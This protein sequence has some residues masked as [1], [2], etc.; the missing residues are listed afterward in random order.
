MPNSLLWAMLVVLW[1]FVV[2]PMFAGRK[3]KVKKTTEATLA[4]RVV[5]SGGREPARARV[6]A[7]GSHPHDAE[8][9][10]PAPTEPNTDVFELEGAVIVSVDPASA[11]AVAASVQRVEVSAGRSALDY[12]DTLDVND[13]AVKAVARDEI[14][15]AADI[16]DDAVRVDETP[17]SVFAATL[18]AAEVVVAKTADADADAPAEGEAE[19][20]ESDGVDYDEEDLEIARREVAQLSEAAEARPRVGRGGFDPDADAERSERRIKFRQRVALGLV[21]LTV[22]AAVVGFALHPFGWVVATITGVALV[23]YLVQ[24]RRQ[25]RAELEL[26]RRRMARKVRADRREQDRRDEDDPETGD[27]PAR[28]RRPGGVV[29]EIDDEDP[30]FEHLEHYDEDPATQQFAAQRRAVG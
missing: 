26:R 13:G 21:A 2:V 30:A 24:L 3:P 8:Y 12:D 28:L 17:T 16:P 5:H 10:R 27:V 7:A 22:L 15:V 4:T 19:A 18:P 14:G 29:L 23:A 1:L 6:R 9:V 11:K 25:V 20:A